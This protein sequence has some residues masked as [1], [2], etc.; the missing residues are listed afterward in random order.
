MR[1]RLRWQTDDACLISAPSAAVR[2][3]LAR[4][5]E[6]GAHCLT[7]RRD[8]VCSR[9]LCGKELG[10][11]RDG[12]AGALEGGGARWAK[13]HLEE[14]A[15]CSPTSPTPSAEDD[16]SLRHIQGDCV[17]IPAASPAWA[18]G[19]RQSDIE[20]LTTPPCR[21][22]KGL[23]LGKP[24]AQKKRATDTDTSGTAPQKA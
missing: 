3:D 7:S 17:N 2:S 21:E 11:A 19:N 5:R 24:S 4:H 6:E 16:I 14:Q 8:P 15:D 1:S 22:T 13:R 18:L 10:Q 20:P 23:S 9:V 12:A